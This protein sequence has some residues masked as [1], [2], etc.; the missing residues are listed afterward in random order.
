[1]ASDPPAAPFMTSSA[2]AGRPSSTKQLGLE[3]LQPELAFDLL[4]GLL[5]Q[6]KHDLLGLF[7]PVCAETVVAA[8]SLPGSLVL[9]HG[10]EQRLGDVVQLAADHPGIAA[11]LRGS[12][13]H[14]ELLD[15]AVVVKERVTEDAEPVGHFG[16]RRCPR[17]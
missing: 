2:S 12:Q 8:V 16:E 11:T 4:G 14:F 7:Q 17:R 1:M 6:A 3:P 9:A 15:G 13:R 5:A 10:Q